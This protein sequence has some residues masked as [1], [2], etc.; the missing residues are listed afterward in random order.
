[1]EK[2]DPETTLLYFL[3]NERIPQNKLQ[4]VTSKV[5]RGNSDHGVIRITLM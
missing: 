3:R 2:P 1:M 4:F 5:S